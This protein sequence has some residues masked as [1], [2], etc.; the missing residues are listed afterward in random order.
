[1]SADASKD[2]VSGRTFYEVTIAPNFEGAAL[3]GL[4]LVPGMPVEVFMKTQ[5]RT[6][7][8]YL[9]QPLLNYFT[10]AFREE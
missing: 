7:L 1:V 4:T 6:P 8:N 10:R 2:E 3:E 5:N 9:T